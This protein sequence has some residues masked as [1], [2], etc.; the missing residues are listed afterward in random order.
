MEVDEKIKIAED[1]LTSK[2][3]R[4]RRTEWSKWLQYFKSNSLEK[5]LNLA[6][7]L[8][9]SV[10]LRRNEKEAYRAIYQIITSNKR[11]L[12][13]VSKQDLLEIFGYISWLIK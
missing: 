10:M 1:I 4:L 5:A 11:Q 2:R 9:N 13:N 7:L 3:I 6:R 8:S 12:S